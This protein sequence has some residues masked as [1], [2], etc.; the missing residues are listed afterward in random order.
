MKNT[1]Y[2]YE[3]LIFPDELEVNLLIRCMFF[4]YLMYAQKDVKANHHDDDATGGNI[5]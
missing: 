3:I 1:K 4:P 2:L 5:H